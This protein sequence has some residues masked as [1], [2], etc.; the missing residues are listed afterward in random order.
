MTTR[1]ASNA[2]RKK[3]PTKRKAPISHARRDRQADVRAARAGGFRFPLFRTDDRLSDSKSK[4]RNRKNASRPGRLVGGTGAIRKA[5]R[6]YERMP[7]WKELDSRRNSR[8]A[9]NNASTLDSISTLSMAL[10]IGA[11]VVAFTLYIGNVHATQNE[12]ARLQSL[13][14]ENSQLRMKLNRVK[15]EYDRMT[16]PAQIYDRA[17]AIGLVESEASVPSV[18]YSPR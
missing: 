16:G 8:S 17:R 9:T 6:D 3:A 5:G 14:S 15:G 1:T 18:I 11:F 10:V 12:L 7:S 13:Q 2:R 4:R